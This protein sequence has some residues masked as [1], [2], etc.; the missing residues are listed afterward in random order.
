MIVYF[1]RQMSVDGRD[2]LSLK[3]KMYV[4]IYTRKKRAV[5]ARL[6]RP[7]ISLLH[8]FLIA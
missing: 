3:K 4:I 2:K 6:R 1:Q 5:E 7:S 8:S